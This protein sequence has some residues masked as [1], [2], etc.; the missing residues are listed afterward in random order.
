MLALY[1]QD[2]IKWSNAQYVVYANEGIHM[3]TIAIQDIKDGDI[4]LV[5][6]NMPW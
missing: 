6:L 5:L 3:V 4:C 1:M 2:W